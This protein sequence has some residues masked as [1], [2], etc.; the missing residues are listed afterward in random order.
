MTKVETCDAL[1]GGKGVDTAIGCIPIENITALTTFVMRWLLG[2]GG[3]IAFLMI[4]FAGFQ[5]MTSSGDPKKLS[6]GQELL[7]SA[8]SG[9]ILVIFSIFILRLIG[10]NILGI[11]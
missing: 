9:L 7:T 6:S 3:G 1:A 10:V 4:L 5:I 11:F 2:I 8:V